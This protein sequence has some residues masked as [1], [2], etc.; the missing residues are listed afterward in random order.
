M[1][2][3]R[4]ES[5]PRRRYA[6]DINTNLGTAAGMV[7][8]FTAKVQAL[9]RIVIPKNIRETEHIVPGQFLKVKL[10]KAE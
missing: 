10:R 1:R 2:G 9:G 6:I 3:V 8:E 4:N 7:E 5:Q